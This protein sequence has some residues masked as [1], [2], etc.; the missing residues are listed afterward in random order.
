MIV[1]LPFAICW[2]VKCTPT[3][4]LYFSHDDVLATF[5]AI[6]TK[7]VQECHNFREFFLC[8]FLITKS[9]G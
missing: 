3:I 2:N 4:I 5:S 1:L 7:P 8:C 9:L 6:S